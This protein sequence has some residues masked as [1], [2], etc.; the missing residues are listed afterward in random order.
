MGEAVVI[1]VAMAMDGAMVINVAM[2]IDGGVA[3]DGYQ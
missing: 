1:V 2:A 3:C